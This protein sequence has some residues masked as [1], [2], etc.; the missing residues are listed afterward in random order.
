MRRNFL[1]CLVIAAL[2]VACNP[3]TDQ[4]E[5]AVSPTDL[6]DES[7]QPTETNAE[8]ESSDT[9]SATATPFVGMFEPGLY[10]IG[11]VDGQLAP[12]IYFGTAPQGCA[13]ERLSGLEGTRS[14]VIVSAGPLRQFYVE[15]LET[16]AAFRLKWCSMSRIDDVPAPADITL[17]IWSGVYLVGRDIQPGLYQ[18][19]GERCYWERLSGLAWTYED[20]IDNDRSDG[21]FYVDIQQSDL[22]FYLRSCGIMPVSEVPAPSEFPTHLEPGMYLVGRDIEAGVYE[23]V[24]EEGSCYWQRRENFGGG[25]EGLIDSAAPE[26][27]FQVRIEP[28]DFLFRL[29]W[30]SVDLV[31]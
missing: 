21:Q 17:P 29:H 28:T 24:G 4:V 19:Q 7:S 18:G 20:I 11:T 23:G 9:T 22:A 8:G 3:A 12:G 5:P 14:E 2:A 25:Q 16:D 6:E 26:G 10:A 30:C 1:L 31:E 15:I 13:W 27:A